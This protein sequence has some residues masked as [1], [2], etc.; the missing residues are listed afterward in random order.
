MR[1]SFEICRPVIVAMATLACQHSVFAQEAV[2]PKPDAKLDAMRQRAE[3]LKLTI[4]GQPEVNRVKP[5]PLL[6]YNDPTITTTDGT[7][8]LWE[9]R[10]RPVAA[11]CLFMDSRDGFQWNY[12][13]VALSEDPF[14]VEGRALWNWQPKN[15]NRGW[16]S[17]ETPIPAE[18]PAQRL[19][20]MKTIA[21]MFEGEESVEN[22]LNRM[23]MLPRPLH[24]YAAP[25]AGVVDGAIF[26]LAIGT[27]P[28]VLVQVEALK[29][30][31]QPWR[32]G[33]A[34]M[35]AA[36]LT[37]RYGEASVWTAAPILNW[38]PRHEYFS[39]YGPDREPAGLPAASGASE[40][41]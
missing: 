3:S 17:L 24:R 16:K 40:A 11:L 13:L 41:P 35:S 9:V 38:N 2:T 26:L 14:R 12:E 18:T 1:S 23:R 25:E 27:N 5:V 10:N 32:V 39:H 7:L 37:V 15:P 21:A 6:R 36:E 22:R 31:P 19:S 34:R 20:Q 29:D 8:W 28:E 4:E 33:F 30:K